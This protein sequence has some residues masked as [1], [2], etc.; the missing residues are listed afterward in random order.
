MRNKRLY[1][2][3]TPAKQTIVAEIRWTVSRGRDTYGYNICSLW[4][5]GKKAYSCNG[6]GYD[7][8]GTCF[9]EWLQDN[10]LDE[11]KKLSTVDFY[12]ISFYCQAENKRHQTYQDGDSVTL[13]G[14]CG[15]SSMQRIAT[16]CGYTI[17]EL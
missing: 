12:G 11:I 16:A 9:G 17:H 1:T 14:A 10:A 4:I 7:M 15:F 13:D 3:T 8:V 2:I 5:N 6:G